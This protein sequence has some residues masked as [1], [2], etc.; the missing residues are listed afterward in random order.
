M[1][2]CKACRCLAAVSPGAAPDGRQR[3]A[4]QQRSPFGL[5]ARDRL[6]QQ[7]PFGTHV[8]HQRPRD[9]PCL[10]RA[11]PSG[12]LLQCLRARAGPV[13]LGALGPHPRIATASSRNIAA[14]SGPGTAAGAVRRDE[15]GFHSTTPF[16]REATRRSRARA[17]RG[18]SAVRQSHA[19]DPPGTRHGGGPCTLRSPPPFPRAQSEL[20]PSPVIGYS[21]LQPRGER[22]PYSRPGCS[23][24]RATAHAAAGHG[25]ALQGRRRRART[26]SPPAA[27]TASPPAASTAPHL[28]PA[29]AARDDAVPWRSPACSP[30]CAFDKCPQHGVLS[31][32][33][34]AAPRPRGWRPDLA[35][36]LRVPVSSSRIPRRER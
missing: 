8:T 12:D 7:P 25:N 16:L 36:A 29:C 24:R 27:S 9:R 28:R 26:R 21:S 20:L 33:W 23:R 11:R 14:A 4:N 13:A 17:T 34:R 32:A 31:F 3:T 22:M 35:P 2:A 10:Q 18:R 19:V 1:H 15:T 6:A 5:Y 30:T